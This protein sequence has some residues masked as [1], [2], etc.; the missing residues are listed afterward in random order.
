MKADMHTRTHSIDPL[1]NLTPA[2]LVRWA[3][4]LRQTPI[5]S[6]LPPSP[7]PW[8]AQSHQATSENGHHSPATLIP[9]PHWPGVCPRI[10]QKNMALG[11][12]GRPQSCRFGTRSRLSHTDSFANP[13]R[14]VSALSRRTQNGSLTK[15]KKKVHLPPPSGGKYSQSGSNY[16]LRMMRIVAA[17][18]GERLT[19]SIKIWGKL[20]FFCCAALRPSRAG[21]TQGTDQSVRWQRGPTMQGDRLKRTGQRL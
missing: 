8:E 18:G 16:S 7:L 15:K 4:K 20:H 19:L 1:I 2:D 21:F 12:E 13:E 6:H 3:N 5:V 9:H 17:G 14:A 10:R 11:V